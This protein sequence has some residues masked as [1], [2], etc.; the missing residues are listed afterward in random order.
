MGLVLWGQL[1]R[2]LPPRSRQVRTQGEVSVCEPGGR[3]ARS[4]GNLI[5]HFHTARTVKNKCLLSLKDPGYGI[6]LQQP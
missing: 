6:L 4:V 2:E 1:P 3:D 5:F